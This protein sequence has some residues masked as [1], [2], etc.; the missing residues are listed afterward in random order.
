MRVDRSSSRLSLS[1]VKS[2]AFDSIVLKLRPVGEIGVAL[3]STADRV[4][5]IVASLRGGVLVSLFRT[6]IETGGLT[7]MSRGGASLGPL[8]P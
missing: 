6:A 3:S 4:E 2:L 5:G 8:P 1:F 7:G